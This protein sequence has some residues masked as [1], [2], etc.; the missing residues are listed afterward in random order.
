MKEIE[1]KTKKEKEEMEKSNGL[2][3]TQNKHQIHLIS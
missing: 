1:K 3:Q 2:L